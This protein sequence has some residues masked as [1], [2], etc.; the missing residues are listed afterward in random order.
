SAVR[1]IHRLVFHIPDN[2]DD[3]DRARRVCERTGGA[4]KPDSLAEWILVWPEPAGG[5]LI[6]DRDRRPVSSIAPGQCA[7]R[8][9]GNAERLE[10]VSRDVVAGGNFGAAGV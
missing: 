7:P 4:A 3:F 10:I 2:P 5:T 1:P 8:Q 9:Q 6:D